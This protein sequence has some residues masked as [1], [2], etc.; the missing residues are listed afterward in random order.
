LRQRWK[1]AASVIGFRDSR[2]TPPEAGF[3][4]RVTSRSSTWLVGRRPC[5]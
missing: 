3:R 4:W 5:H 1:R 2:K